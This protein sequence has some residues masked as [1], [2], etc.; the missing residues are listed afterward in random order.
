MPS[1]GHEGVVELIKQE[2]DAAPRFLR[3][4]LGVEL[5]AY[6][7]VRLEPADLTD[8]TPTEYR[9]DA[10]VTLRDGSGDVPLLGIVVE[11]QLTW[12]AEKKWSWPVYVATLRARLRCPAVLLVIC[13]DPA[14]RAPARGRSSWVIRAWCCARWC[15]ARTACPW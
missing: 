8:L 14:R 5:P 4:Q 9:A 3:D 7:Q 2:P 12:K 13:P 1:S 6:D 11:V 15:S 10:V